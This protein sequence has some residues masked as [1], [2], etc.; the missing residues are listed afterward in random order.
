MIRGYTEPTGDDE[1]NTLYCTKRANVVYKRLIGYE[2]EPE[3]MTTEV[4]G[5]DNNPD[6]SQARRVDIALVD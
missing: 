4:G 1:Q 3:R 6:T 2:I 5:V